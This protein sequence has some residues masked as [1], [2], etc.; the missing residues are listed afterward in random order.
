MLE[1]LEFNRDLTG[2]LLATIEEFR[3]GMGGHNKRILDILQQGIARMPSLWW[4]KS[5]PRGEEEALLDF[6]QSKSDQ[7][8]ETARAL[9]ALR[10]GE[11][12]I[13]ANKLARARGEFEKC[14]GLRAVSKTIHKE[15]A[16]R[17][18]IVGN[19]N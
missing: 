18:W 2:R 5:V 8:T 19:A 10:Q 9:F 1:S 16:G 14:D 13:R 7:L 4:W 12:Y 15:L 6:L 3:A 11:F 17:F